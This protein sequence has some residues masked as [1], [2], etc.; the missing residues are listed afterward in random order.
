MPTGIAHRRGILQSLK[1]V[2]T[3]STLATRIQQIRLRADRKRQEKG[4]SLIEAS[5]VLALSAVVVAGVMFYYQSASDN[6]KLQAAQAELMGVVSTVNSLYAGQSTYSGL[7]TEQIIKGGQL[8]PSLVDTSSN[9]IK[10]PFGGS[11]AAAAASDVSTYTL[12]MQGV[13]RAP[14]VSMGSTQIGSSLV[15]LQVNS[16]AVDL[17][18]AS[19]VAACTSDTSNS[20]VWTMR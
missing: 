18:P 16:K 20:L 13:P 7:T 10:N 11:V 2:K 5:M 19:A 3:M 4:L 14:C 1:L 9:T 15:Q 6:N 17:S 8:P 12:T